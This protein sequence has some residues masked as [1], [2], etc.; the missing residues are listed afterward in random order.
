[1]MVVTAS[2]HDCKLASDFVRHDSLNQKRYRLFEAYSDLCFGNT[3]TVKSTGEDRY[4]RTLAHIVLP[5]GKELNREL[6][7][8]GYTWCRTSSPTFTGDC[9]DFSS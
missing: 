8:Q 5:N 3:V 7:R 6:V 2:S 4:R 9:L 1:M